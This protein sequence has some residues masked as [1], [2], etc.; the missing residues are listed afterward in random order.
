MKRKA[1]QFLF[2]INVRK[3]DSEQLRVLYDTLL[4]LAKRRNITPIVIV[5]E[6]GRRW[7]IWDWVE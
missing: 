6:K 7:E 2:R 1:R 3:L 4:A 5:G